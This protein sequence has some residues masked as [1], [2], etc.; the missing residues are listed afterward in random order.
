M[1]SRLSHPGVA[2]IYDFDSQ[3]G[4]DFLVM[5]LVTGA[6]LESRITQ[7]DLSIG[8]LTRIGAQ[9]ADA[10]HDAHTRGF[11]H[12]DLKPAN[13]VLTDS[14]Q[15]KILDFGL[16]LLLGGGAASGKLTQTG[17]VVFSDVDLAN[18]T[19]LQFFDGVNSFLGT[20]FAPT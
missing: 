5:E 6:T 4:V 18:T 17:G 7:A 13:V 15:P 11:L 12:R 3:D 8:D 10:L 16:A 20:F 19:S 2:T 1:L 9:I 14:G